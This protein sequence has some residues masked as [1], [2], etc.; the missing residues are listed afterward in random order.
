[1]D[2]ELNVDKHGKKC[3]KIQEFI[4][5]FAFSFYLCERPAE[6]KILMNNSLEYNPLGWLSVYCIAWHR[7]T[8]CVHIL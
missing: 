2:N 4:N 5:Y 6:Y 3:N 1:M 8:Y 7:K